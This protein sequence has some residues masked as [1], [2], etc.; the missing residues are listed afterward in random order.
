MTTTTEPPWLNSSGGIAARNGTNSH[1]V[2]FTTDGNAPFTPTAGTLL[3]FLVYGGVT[4]AA[5]G[6]TEQ[7]Q[8]V[9]SG[10]LS[11]FTRTTQS[12]D[13]GI[14]VTHN[15]SNYPVAWKVYQFPAGSS[16]DT[17][18]GANQTGGTGNEM[19]TL[20]GLTG[21]AGNERVIMAALGRAVTS[22]GPSAASA[23]WS[24]GGIV[25]DGD[26]FAAFSAT[27]GAYITTAHAINV[28]ATS[29]LPV[30][31]TSYTGSGPNDRQTVVFAINAAVIGGT[32]PFSKDLVLR[33]NVRNA[34][35]KDLSLAW[36]L[37]NSVVK[38]LAL[39]WNL[40]NGI[41]K[42]LSAVW[43]VRNALTKDLA[44]GWNVRA[45][46]AK[47]VALAWDVRNAVTKDLVLRWNTRAGI[48]KDLSVV[49]N[50][51]SGIFRDLVVRWNIG[52][53]LTKDLRLKWNVDGSAPA[54]GV[55][56]R[57][58]AAQR[59][60]TARFIENDPTTAA[61]IPRDRVLTGGGG[62]QYT[63]GTPR[64]PQTFKLS[65]LAYDQRP[66]ITVAGVERIMD[67]HLIGP[68]NMDIAVGDHWTDDAGTKYEV[69]GLT[70][71]WDYEV[72][73]VVFR[74]VPREAK[75]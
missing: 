65:L 69:G 23:T 73:A 54:P 59:A 35:T 46:I 12:G 8:P 42:D 40:R 4:H 67:F 24:G 74:H 21:G 63:D 17:G 20:S 45:A 2:N 57:Q 1:T 26:F 25:E 6:W 72:K 37:R 47:N 11:V 7:L 10:E 30:I 66:T 16:Y 5:S 3:V 60:A 22:T 53:V 43:N 61:L 38:D 50:I 29:Y 70:E 31:T 18:T 27:D 68:Y 44:L 56:L 32:T 9:N 51:G 28:T 41:T 62:Y 49:W 33:W 58:L 39:R 15:G 52:G 55:N 36:N 34:V 64:A 19:P 14:T 48:I 13:T 71:G 75:P